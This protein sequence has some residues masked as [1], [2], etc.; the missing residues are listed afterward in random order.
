MAADVNRGG[1][2]G[3]LRAVP[4][5]ISSLRSDIPARSPRGPAKHKMQL[6]RPLGRL[7]RLDESICYFCS[8]ID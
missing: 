7:C 4:T 6:V 2:R 3:S 8:E 5:G 1:Y